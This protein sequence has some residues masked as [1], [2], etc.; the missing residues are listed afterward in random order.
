MFVKMC[1]V[2]FSTMF[3]TFQCNFDHNSMRIRWIFDIIDCLNKIHF[4]LQNEF[5]FI[6]FICWMYML[7]KCEIVDI[8]KR[9][10]NVDFRNFIKFKFNFEVSHEIFLKKF[11]NKFVLYINLLSTKAQRWLKNEKIQTIWKIDIDFDEKKWISILKSKIS[12][13]H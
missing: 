6:Y 9:L 11:T 8:A 2:S 7:L 4:E 1:C 5:S 10:R 13:L 3:A 12:I